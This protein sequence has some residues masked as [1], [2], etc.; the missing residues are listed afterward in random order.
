VPAARHAA[1]SAAT[2][3]PHIPC[4][5]ISQCRSDSARHSAR[6]RQVVHTVIAAA[7]SWRALPISTLTG[8]H[9]SGSRLLSVQ[10]A[11]LITRTHNARSANGMATGGYGGPP[12]ARSTAGAAGPSFAGAGVRETAICIPLSQNLRYRGMPGR[13]R[14]CHAPLAS[15]Q[16]PVLPSRLDQR[17]GLLPMARPAHGMSRG[18]ASRLALESSTWQPLVC[19]W[20]PHRQAGSGP[21]RRRFGVLRPGRWPAAA[22]A[23]PAE[24][25]EDGRCQRRQ[26]GRD[27]QDRAQPGAGRVCRSC[28]TGRPS[29]PPW[30]RQP[31]APAP[32]RQR[33]RV[34]CL[35]PGHVLVPGQLGEYREHRR[36]VRLAGM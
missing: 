31:L 28:A 6:T 18:P 10:R 29:F 22:H 32:K 26:H 20:L 30:P 21:A 17:A 13:R 15:R 19:Q 2:R 7:A 35:Q 33:P 8:N 27:Q 5:P 14:S 9:W 4:W 3:P 1:R 11:C 23:A 34:G 12:V 24:T 36:Q 25:E 16:A